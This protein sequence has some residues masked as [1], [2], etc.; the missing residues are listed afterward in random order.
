MQQSEDEVYFVDQDSLPQNYPTHLHE[1]IFWEELGRTVATFGFLEGVLTRA[2]FA[3]TSTIKYNESDWEEAFY[4]WIPKIEKSLS[5]QLFVLIDTYAVAIRSN[6][7]AN[8]DDLKDLLETLRE[9]ARTRNV[10]CHGSWNKPNEA[11]A[12]IPF[13]VNRKNEKFETPIDIAFL[14]QTRNHVAELS[15]SVMNSVTQLGWQF[16][17]TGGPGK[18]IWKRK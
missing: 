17:G 8:K 16:P 12:S 2:I 13:F 3:L 14:K 4:E 1:N 11:G 7:A 5:D 9:A 15:S 10:L 6:P 18:V